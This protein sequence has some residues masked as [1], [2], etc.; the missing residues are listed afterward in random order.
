[1]Y[2]REEKEIMKTKKKV[3]A[4]L[5]LIENLAALTNELKEEIMSEIFT[6]ID[7]VEELNKVAAGKKHA[8]VAFRKMKH[9][10]AFDEL[11]D[12]KNITYPHIKLNMS[13]ER[14][15]TSVSTGSVNPLETGVRQ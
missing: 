3:L 12:G 4:Q 5:K 2:G 9:Y 13:D 10:H 8:D 7:A 6:Q 15:T 1:M 14:I 11:E